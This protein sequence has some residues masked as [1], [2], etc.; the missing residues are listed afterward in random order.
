MTELD[1][2]NSPETILARVKEVLPTPWEW[3]MRGAHARTLF[4]EKV[5]ED[6]FWAI[7]IGSVIESRI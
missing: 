5:K 3:H 7:K 2:C 4:Y 6:G 1:S